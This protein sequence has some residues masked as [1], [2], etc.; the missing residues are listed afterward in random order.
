[1]TPGFR[2]FSFLLSNTF[3]YEL[4]LLKLSMNANIAKMQIFHKFKYD[5]RGHSRAQIMTFLIKIFFFLVC[6]EG[7]GICAHLLTLFSLLLIA[8]TLPVSLCFVVKVVQV[9]KLVIVY[10][11]QCWG[12]RAWPF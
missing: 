3:V 9:S 1:M 5:L 2:D 12:A 7:P 11:N 10:T 8:A 6:D 4:I